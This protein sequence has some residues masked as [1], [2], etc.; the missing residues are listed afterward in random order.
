[1]PRRTVTQLTVSAGLVWP[2]LAVAVVQIG[3]LLVLKAALGLVRGSVDDAA[4][5]V[6]VPAVPMPQPLAAVAAA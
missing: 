3:G 1:M 2:L 5:T 4:V 6:E